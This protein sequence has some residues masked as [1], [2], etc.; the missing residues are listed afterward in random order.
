MAL[1]SATVAPER[2]RATLLKALAAD[3]PI[4]AVLHDELQEALPWMREDA[5]NH[6]TADMLA[7]RR[8]ETQTP[9]SEYDYNET[10]RTL[11][12][13]Q[14][15]ELVESMTQPR[16]S[17]EPDS[18]DAIIHIYANL[19]AQHALHERLAYQVFRPIGKIEQALKQ[20]LQKE[21]P[22]L[23]AE[24][25]AKLAADFT[26]HHRAHLESETNA[27]KK[28]G[29]AEQQAIALAE[30]LRRRIGQPQKTKRTDTRE[31][32]GEDISFGIQ[33]TL[34]CWATDFIDPY[35]G[36]LIQDKFKDDS[37][38]ST[39]AHTWGGEIIGDTA[40][41]FTFLAVQK[42]LPQPVEWLKSAAAKLGNG[43]YDWA[44]K[45]SL[46]GWA[47]EQHIDPNSDAYKKKLEEWKDFQADN[48]AK[49]S[50]ISVSSIALNV[51]TQKA[52]GNTH[53]LSVIT[54]SKVIG[55]AITMASM[56]GLRVLIPKTTKELDE[57]LSKKYFTPVIRATQRAFGAKDAPDNDDRATVGAHTA[58]LKRE[59]AESAMAL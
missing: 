19:R 50:V 47:R 33:Q 15:Q 29:P 8:A 48:F 52:M 49:S 59:P 13:A 5:L 34:A 43:F 4:A 39:M 38:S 36:K 56:L 46:S 14:L 54:M 58:R 26:T 20:F 55:A 23:S 57:E 21:L 7:T 28:N 24:E 45:R 32:F 27:L 12:P 25:A 1:L 3:G 2:L 17:V 16:G 44:G 22:E 11:T 9:S 30:R 6:A 40:A 42:Y 41:F 37:H 31:K 10:H 53:K 51:A 35:V 18:A